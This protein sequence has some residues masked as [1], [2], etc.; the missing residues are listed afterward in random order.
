MVQLLLAMRSRVWRVRRVRN[1]VWYP[2]SAN[3]PRDGACS[4]WRRR[5]YLISFPAPIMRTDNENSVFHGC[6][7]GSLQ[8][9]IPTHSAHA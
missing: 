1:G 3:V 4:A 5:Q 7:S 9:A 6:Y 8:T 2:F